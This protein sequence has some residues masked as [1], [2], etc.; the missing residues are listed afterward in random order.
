MKKVY[1]LFIAV[2]FTLTA[3]AQ[4]SGKNSIVFWQPDMQVSQEHPILIQANKTIYPTPLRQSANMGEERTTGIAGGRWY[5]YF[6]I[7]D[8]NLGWP[9]TTTSGTR[10]I[11]FAHL[12]WDS[13]VSY[14]YSNGPAANEWSAV[15]QIIDPIRYFEYIDSERTDVTTNDT[16]SK[17]G[18]I[19]IT[20]TTSYTVDSIRIRAAYIRERHNII[21]TLFISVAP[22]QND[23]YYVKATGDNSTWFNHNPNIPSDSPRFFSPQ[24]LYADS[25]NRAILPDNSATGARQTLDT[26]LINADSSGFA[27]DTTTMPGSILYTYTLYSLKVKPNTI[28]AGQHFA[29]SLAFKS[30]DTT[31]HVNHTSDSV[32]QYNDFCPVYGFEASPYWMSDWQVPTFGN[33]NDYNGSCYLD[34]RGRPSGNTTT[35]PLVN[36]TNSPAR[37]LSQFAIQNYNSTTGSGSPDQYLW[38]DAHVTCANCKTVRDAVAVKNVTNILTGVKAYPNPATDKITINYTLSQ[39]ANITLH[40]TNTIGQIVNVQNMGT[41]SSGKMTI[42]TSELSAGIYIYTI[43]A[44]NVNYSGRFTVIH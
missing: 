42:N 15:G 6:D 17:P 9:F 29:I 1:L 22:Q 3:K 12:W 28:P 26:F 27:K 34:G 20:A 8:A 40:V 14:R 18:D 5:R 25:I 30:G 39:A 7:I 33:Y 11:S 19:T 32:T 13:T 38:M 37:W 35:Y 43:S 2:I 4:S 21:D 16:I 10:N 44:Q 23:F 36:H 31:H 24:P 41:A